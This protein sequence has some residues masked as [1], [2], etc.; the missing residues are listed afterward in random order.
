MRLD[1]KTI[2][3][4]GVASGIGQA[5]AVKAMAEGARVIGVDQS[6]DGAPDGVELILGDVTDEAV[7]ARAVAAALSG[8]AGRIDGLATIAG[9]SSSGTAID[10]I[11]PDAW[12]RVFEVNVKATWRWLVGVLPA[13]R[14][15]G[16]G[17]VVAIASQLAFGGGRF[18]APYIASKGAIVSLVKTAGFELAPDNVRV[19]A[20]APGAIDTP[21]LNRSMSRADDPDAAREYSRNRH[22]MKRF[23][24]AEE[25]ANGVVFLLSDESSF[26]TGEVLTIDGGWRA[27]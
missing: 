24:R 2:I 20:V 23:G 16:G 27:A 3:V 6:G 9:I 13:M 15:G 11:E 22:A 12:D 10:A 19:N 4:T 5:S 18:N 26:T 7:I 21:M 8:A 14:E 17:S 25:I 1:G